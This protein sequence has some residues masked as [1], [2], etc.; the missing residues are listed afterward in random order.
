[1]SP[2][3]MREERALGG[4][5]T[6]HLLAAGSCCWSPLAALSPAR[7]F[8][9]EVYG[10]GAAAAGL[11][12]ARLWKEVNNGWRNWREAKNCRELQREAEQSEVKR[13]SSLRP[14]EPCFSPVNSR[15]LLV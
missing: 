5:G 11:S 2:L 8:Q 4:M 7:H 15:P 12:P 10:C 6:L 3:K 9:R 1:M 13:C 14:A